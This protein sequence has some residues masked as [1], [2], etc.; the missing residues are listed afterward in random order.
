L[1]NISNWWINNSCLLY[2][3][4]LSATLSAAVLL[5]HLQ[6]TVVFLVTMGHLLML[7]L[8]WDLP[9][10]AQLVFLKVLYD[11]A[12]LMQSCWVTAALPI[13]AEIES[14]TCKCGIIGI[15]TVN[16]PARLML[17]RDLLLYY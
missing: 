12:G 5:S 4:P 13:T 3:T 10:L 2:A 8:H 7:P 6:N 16:G 11:K 14:S 17:Q 1:Y 9:V 15:N